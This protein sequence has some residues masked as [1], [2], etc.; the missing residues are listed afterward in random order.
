[1]EALA[2]LMNVKP[3]LGRDMGH[4][5]GVNLHHHDPLVQRLVM[6]QGMQQRDRH[7]S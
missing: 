3:A 5:F 1:M 4:V 7:L 6:L 2:N